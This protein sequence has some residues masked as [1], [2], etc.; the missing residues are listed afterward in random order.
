MVSLLLARES[1]Q[2][3]LGL[4]LEAPVF[5]GPV[6]VEWRVEGGLGLAPGLVPAAERD[7]RFG[8]EDVGDDALRVVGEGLP[9][10][11]L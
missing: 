10:V 2:Q 6:G 8:E 3:R 7:E 9:Q 11:L 5:R 4:L 1:L